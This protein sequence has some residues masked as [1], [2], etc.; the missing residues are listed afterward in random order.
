MTIDNT[1]PI[2]SDDNLHVCKMI[3]TNNLLIRLLLFKNIGSAPSP[4]PSMSSTLFAMSR[5]HLCQDITEQRLEKAH[6]HCWKLSLIE[7][8]KR[9]SPAFRIMFLVY[10][11]GFGDDRASYNVTL[12]VSI[13]PINMEALFEN[14]IFEVLLKFDVVV[15]VENFD[16]DTVILNYNLKNCSQTVSNQVALMK[17]FK[18]V[19]IRPDIK[20]FRIN[21][22]AEMIATER[23]DIKHVQDDYAEIYYKE[24]S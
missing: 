11:C 21:V 15:S 23:F 4:K 18:D 17:Q 6:S 19:I 12:V 2:S 10:P 16:H 14:Y 24:Q 8:N 5:K 22:Q 7:R 13:T 20:K 3:H 9:S 1:C